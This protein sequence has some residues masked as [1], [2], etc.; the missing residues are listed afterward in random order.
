[1]HLVIKVQWHVKMHYST[2]LDTHYALYSWCK[3]R[4]R[5]HVGW[6]LQRILQIKKEGFVVCVYHAH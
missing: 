6:I 1:M 2:F 3:L 5:R 4:H